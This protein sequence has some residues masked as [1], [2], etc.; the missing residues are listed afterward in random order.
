MERMNRLPRM[1]Q[2]RSLPPF[3]SF[4]ALKGRTATFH[5]PRTRPK[6]IDNPGLQ[7]SVSGGRSSNTAAVLSLGT[8]GK[9]RLH[10]GR[11]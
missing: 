8:I 6:V 4:Q 7:G 2:P 5:V 10:F 1:R 11:K 9:P 3:I